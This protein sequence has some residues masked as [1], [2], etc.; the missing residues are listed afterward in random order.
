MPVKM[1]PSGKYNLN[2]IDWDN[3]WE[4]VFEYHNQ[5]QYRNPSNTSNTTNDPPI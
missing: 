4:R 1:N 3:E 2:F 5:N